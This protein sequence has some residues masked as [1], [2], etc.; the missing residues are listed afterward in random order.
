M[1]LVSFDGG[2]IGALRVTSEG[3]T[4][5]VDLG[6]LVEGA[7]LWPP[8]AMLRLIAEFDS[9]RSSVEERISE[10]SGVSLADVRLGPPVEWPSK[11]VA[12]PTNYED[13]IRE[14]NSPNR[15]DRNGFFLKAP[16]SLCGPG[17]AIEMP[18]VDPQREVHHEAELAI[19]LGRTCRNVP[20]EQALECVFGYMCL[21]DL[22]VRGA[23][24]RVMRKSYDT[25]T[26]C[27]PAIVTAD[28]VP[29]PGNLEIELRVNGDLRQSGNTKDLILGIPE[30]VELV[31]S[32][33][34]IYPGDVFASGTPAGVGPVHPGDLVEMTIAGLGELIM[35]V[36]QKASGRNVALDAPREQPA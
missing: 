12:F 4:E 21:I 18:T 20:A 9:L 28:E 11:L 10:S 5:V 1:K 25:F 23:G 3:E 29:N 7:G 32:V 34:T 22:T 27:G 26:P 2:H 13:H 6:D 17:V 16:S 30:M 31:S 8:T 14:M 15:A 19:V 35:P 33:S 36:V 24:E